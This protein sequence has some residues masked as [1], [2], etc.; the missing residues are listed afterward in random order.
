MITIKNRSWR[1]VV[2]VFIA[3]LMLSLSVL[4]GIFY[5]VRKCTGETINCFLYAWWNQE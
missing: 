4:E 5:G 3:P 2:L 1:R